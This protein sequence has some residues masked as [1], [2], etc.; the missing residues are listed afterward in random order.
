MI[1]NAY[2]STLY[3]EKYVEEFLNINIDEFM[4]ILTDEDIDV[5]GL[6]EPLESGLPSCMGD[7]AADAS[8]G[9]INI[10]MK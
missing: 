8:V 5:L 6:W 3:A 9:G 4:Y 10:A 2:T 1:F 7:A